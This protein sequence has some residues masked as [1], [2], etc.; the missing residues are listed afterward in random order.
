MK[1]TMSAHP[2]VRSMRADRGR[3]ARM[4]LALEVGLAVGGFGGAYH[5]ITAPHDAMPADVL[6]RTPFSSWVIPGFLLALCVAVPAVVV[7]YGTA[8]RRTYAHVGHPMLGVAL[9]GWIVVQ[10]LVIGPT[11]WLQPAMFG[12]GLAILGLGAVN[13]RRWHTG[14]QTTPAERAAAMSGDDLV[15][16]PHFVATRA[17]TINAPPQAVWPWIVQMG[18]GRAGWYSYDRLD[19]LGRR[20]AET[21]EPK[22]QEVHVGDPVPMSGRIDDRTAFRVFAFT[23]YRIMVW[24]KPDS[25]W[26][27]QLR[28]TATG[29][30]RLVTRVRARYAGAG[31]L[32]AV[33]LMEIG[34][35]P[36]MRRC[37]LGIKA[38]A[39]QPSGRLTI[40]AG[41]PS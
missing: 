17:I 16:R 38:R 22:W 35:F 9:M 13:Y 32:L 12:W 8:T 36:M 41:E 1:T 40:H 34:D 15:S 5:L 10:I 7:A 28:P 21:I 18:F 37:L 6:A 26:T 30:T 23:P 25:T 19:N 39:E 24:A 31:A 14:W 3:F 27:W 20:S 11:S 29:G 4:L 33:P 2:N